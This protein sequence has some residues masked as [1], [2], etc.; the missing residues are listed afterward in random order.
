MERRGRCAP[1][2]RANDSAISR[3]AAVPELVVGAVA[4]RIGTR[5]AQGAQAVENRP[6]LGPL[7]VGRGAHRRVRTHRPHH[8][9]ERPQRIVIDGTAIEA[10]VVVVRRQ[11]HVFVAQRRIAAAQDAHHVARRPFHRFS[12]EV[13]LAADRGRGR[14]SRRRRRGIAAEDRRG[15]PPAEPD[16]RNGARIARGI[17]DGPALAD[18]GDLLAAELIESHDPHG[19]GV[20]IAAEQRADGAPIEPGRRV[21]DD[22]LAGDTRGRHEMRRVG[23][24]SRKHDRRVVEHLRR[25]GG[26]DGQEV[27]DELQRGAAARRQ[28]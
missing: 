6:N 25:H 9:V 17:G 26:T 22:E 19:C 1:V 23:D 13:E 8:A 24:G 28:T 16:E 3:I 12:R 5:P 21:E 27:G 7:F 10:H 20:A 15:G 18:A 4:D 2:A 11:R 14:R